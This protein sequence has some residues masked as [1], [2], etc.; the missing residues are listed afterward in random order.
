MRSWEFLP[1]KR[2]DVQIKIMSSPHS[3]HTR[4]WDG[5][6]NSLLLAS[7]SGPI[8][9]LSPVSSTASSP[10]ADSSKDNRSRESQGAHPICLHAVNASPP[11]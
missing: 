9:S 10:V 1:A 6:A 3:S 5:K 7:I 4:K 11:S 8:P 2:E